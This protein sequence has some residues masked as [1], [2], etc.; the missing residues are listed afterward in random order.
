MTFFS[1]KAFKQ[2]KLFQMQRYSHYSALLGMHQRPPGWCT[3][4]QRHR[5]CQRVMEER[6]GRCTLLPQCSWKTSQKDTSLN[7]EISVNSR[8]RE[9]KKHLSIT[10]KF[11]D[12]A[13]LTKVDVQERSVGSLHQ[14]LLTGP[15]QSFVHEVHTVSHQRAQSL[16]IPLKKNSD[17]NIFLYY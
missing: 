9:K 16:S 7:R 14:D 1:F 4:W 10:I 13:V 6:Q 2:F 5:L 17:A 15:S 11:S 3:P 8:R 12:P